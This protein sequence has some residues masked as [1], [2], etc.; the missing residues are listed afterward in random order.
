MQL[1]LTTDYAVR[2]ILYLARNGKTD[3]KRLSD[4]LKISQNYIKKLMTSSNLSQFVSSKAGQDGGLELRIS[5]DKIT[6]LDIVKAMENEILITQCLEDKYSCNICV[7]FTKEQCP[8]RKCYVNIQK[9]L[10]EKL[11]RISISS[12]AD[13][14][15]LDMKGGSTCSYSL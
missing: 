1:K 13:Q 15:V 9:M 14:I 11:S 12:L 6:L 3:S 4:N 5:A 8:I 10:E 2:I 7:S